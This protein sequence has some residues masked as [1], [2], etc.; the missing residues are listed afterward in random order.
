MVGFKS[1]RLTVIGFAEQRRNGAYW[2]CRCECGREKIIFAFHV[3]TGHTKSCG[4]WRDDFPGRRIHGKADTLMYKAWQGMWTRCTNPRATSFKYYGAK[5]VL[6]CDR[7]RRFENFFEDMGERPAGL[8]LDRIDP[9]G[10]YEPTNCRWA[11]R[12][13]QQKNKRRK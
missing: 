2:L 7:W 10:N 12:S 6:V 9:N 1:Y 5:G 3:R 8:S 13:E 11:T 4:C